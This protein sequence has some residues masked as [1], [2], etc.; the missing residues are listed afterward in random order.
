MIGHVILKGRDVMLCAERAKGA[1]EASY[2][3]QCLVCE[4]G[5][6]RVDNNPKPVAVW[7][8]EHARH[9]GLA[10]GQFLVTTQKHWRVDPLPSAPGAVPPAGGDASAAVAP[11]V[12]P[13]RQ[14]R[15]RTGA[16]ARPRRRT[17]L[18]PLRSLVA[19][20]GR[21]VGLFGMLPA[22]RRGRTA[23]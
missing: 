22:A 19:V 18:G 16:H 21:A 12:S 1:P 8:L 13:P 14:P 5:S 6:G 3:A 20:A 17:V 2:G 7:A 23:S 15:H 10:H 9:N 4:A 11:A